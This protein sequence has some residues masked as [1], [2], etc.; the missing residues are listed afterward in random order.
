MYHTITSWLI[1]SSVVETK[2]Y[3]YRIHV[4]S[5]SRDYIV[6]F[7]SHSISN[8]SLGIGGEAWRNFLLFLDETLIAVEE[9]CHRGLLKIEC[10]KKE[11]NETGRF[12]VR[13]SVF[14]RVYRKFNACCV[15]QQTCIRCRGRKERYLYR[16]LTIFSRC[17][18]WYRIMVDLRQSL[19]QCC[20]SSLTY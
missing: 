12:N 15:V 19:M 8:F 1:T 6:N 4:Q 16:I 3:V 20:K 13:R 10:K 17:T 18:G 14:L 5:G 7:T 2:L 11:K 9:L